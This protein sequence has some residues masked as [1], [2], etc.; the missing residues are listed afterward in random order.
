M[1]NILS[2]YGLVDARISASEKDLPV[3]GIF[4]FGYL[5]GQDKIILKKKK[6]NQSLKYVSIHLRE[7][8]DSNR[9]RNQMSSMDK[10]P[11]KAFFYHLKLS[12]SSFSY[13][14]YARALM[15]TGSKV[16]SNQV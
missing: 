4:K 9:Y 14:R 15:R 13:T 12:V 2:Y 1:N 11:A 5:E 6:E 10:P 3:C 7:I 8:Y 16:I